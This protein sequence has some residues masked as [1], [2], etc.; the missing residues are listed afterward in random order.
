MVMSAAKEHPDK[1]QIFVNG[2][3]TTWDKKKITYTEVVNL[4]FPSRGENEMFTVTYDHGPRNSKGTLVEGQE[5]EVTNGMRFV[6]D[7]TG[8]S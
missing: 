6:I 7:R 5:V 8:K 2:Q 1:F 3:H 4:A